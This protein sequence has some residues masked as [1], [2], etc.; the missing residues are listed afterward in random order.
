MATAW[1]GGAVE[2]PTITAQTRLGPDGVVS[3]H[4]LSFDRHAENIGDTLQKS[5]VTLREFTYCQL[6]ALR[7]E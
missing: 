4:S 6:R 7:K 2:R 1:V 5:N 3:F